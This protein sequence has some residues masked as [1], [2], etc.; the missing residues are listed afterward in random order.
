MASIEELI[1]AKRA[2]GGPTVDPQVIASMPPV[3]GGGTRYTL[4]ALNEEAAAVAA[5]P[6]GTRNDT[7]N[8]AAFRLGRYVGSGQLDGQTVT[9]ALT[10]AALAA[11]LGEAE[12]ASTLR[13]GGLAGAAH[14]KDAPEPWEPTQAPPTTVLT[15]DTLATPQAEG[16]S[17]T[18]GE[19]DGQGLSR[20][21][22]YAQ[23]RARQV[24]LQAEQLR[25]S[26]EARDIVALE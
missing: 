15:P 18:T 23:W 6:E 19:N 25:I 14:P 7:L 12:I 5:A 2:K 16:D 21:E 26:A 22:Q 9:D 24:V 11:G 20:E 13:S 17:D 8:M 1:A 3:A 10:R 4:A